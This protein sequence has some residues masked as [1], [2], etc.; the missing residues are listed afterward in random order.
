[1][2]LNL[3]HLAIVH[4]VAEEASVSRAAD[5]LAE[6]RGLERGELRIGASTTIAVYLLPAVFVAFRKAY[7]GVR[8][9]VDI[10]NASEIE[11]RLL[12]GNLDVAMSEGEPDAAAFN[13]TPFMT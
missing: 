5:R 1:M 10:G 3:N 7:P 8:L 6:L 11:G 2:S 12:A 13:A 9:T 4:A